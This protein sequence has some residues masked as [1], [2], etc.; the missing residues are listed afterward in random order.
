MRSAV[1]DGFFQEI[2]KKASVADVLRVAKKAAPK[3]L[4]GGVGLGGAAI[5]GKGLYDF[6]DVMSN[7]V[8][9]E[10]FDKALKSNPKITR[11]E[12]PA[13]AKKM[14]IKGKIHMPRG[15]KQSYK[16]LREKL[17][18]GPV[19]SFLVG[20]MVMTAEDQPT[21]AFYVPPKKGEPKDHMVVVTPR[22]DKFIL[23]HELG[24]AKDLEDLGSTEK[25]VETS[26]PSLIDGFKQFVT[27]EPFKRT[28]VKS[29]ERAWD[30]ILKEIKKDKK[31]K[32][33]REL[34]LKTYNDAG[35]SQT[36]Q[37]QIVAGGLMAYYG[38]KA[39]KSMV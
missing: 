30:N 18:Y 15:F 7:A 39:L 24:H 19:S 28:V 35:R 2:D 12:I 29:E 25:F 4:A 6:A 26:R 13:L 32:N 38:A 22:A 21:A 27:D 16:I 10:E 3:V 14:G 23:S 34:A 37:K 17:G 31:L 1:L 36:A 11:K 8:T 9:L 20:L 33:I 5:A